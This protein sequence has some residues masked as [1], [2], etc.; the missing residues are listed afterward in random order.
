[1]IALSKDKVVPSRSPNSWN[2]RDIFWMGI[3]YGLYL[4]LS[5]WVLYHVATKMTFFEEK[6]SLFSLDDRYNSLEAWCI[7]DIAKNPILMANGTVRPSTV[8]VQAA[9]I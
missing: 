9:S 3:A 2:L 8:T 4:T 5:S 6:C 1:M 7:N